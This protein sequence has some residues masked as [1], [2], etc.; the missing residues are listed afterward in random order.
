MGKR[1]FKEGDKGQIIC[2]DCAKLVS[3]TCKIRDVNFE[4]MVYNVLVDVCDECD[5]VVAIPSSSI[6]Q[7]RAMRDAAKK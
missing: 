1:I 3:T 7:I 4:S 6:V 2:H 5:C